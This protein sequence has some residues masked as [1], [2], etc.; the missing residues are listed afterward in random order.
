MAKLSLRREEAEE[1]YVLLCPC[2]HTWQ[3]LDVM[4]EPLRREVSEL[5]RQIEGVDRDMKPLK[6]LCEKKVSGRR[7]WLP[8]RMRWRLKMESLH[9]WMSH[10]AG[11]YLP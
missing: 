10:W 11:I 5:R 8:C 2:L 6:A 4:E 7:H 3:E 9:K 1:C